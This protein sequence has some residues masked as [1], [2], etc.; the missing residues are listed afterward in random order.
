MA[1]LF[2]ALAFA[3]GRSRGL[4]KWLAG[5]DRIVTAVPRMAVW[6]GIESGRLRVLRVRRFNYLVRFTLLLFWS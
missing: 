4:A 1:P 3:G 6:R 5:A 2:P